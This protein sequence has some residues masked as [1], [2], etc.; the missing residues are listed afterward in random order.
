MTALVTGVFKP[1]GFN[2]PTLTKVSKYFI[3]GKKIPAPTETIFVLIHCAKIFREGKQCLEPA[4]VCMSS[5][6]LKLKFSSN[7]EVVRVWE[8][9]WWRWGLLGWRLSLATTV[10]GA[11]FQEEETPSQHGLNFS[12][13]KQWRGCADFSISKGVFY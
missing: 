9:L 6:K 4:V 3:I 11:S 13:H 10:K 8:W 7:G 1:C 12:R 5:P 2:R